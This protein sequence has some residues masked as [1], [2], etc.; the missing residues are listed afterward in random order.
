M[1]QQTGYEKIILDSHLTPVPA[2]V[3]LNILAFM[4]ISAIFCQGNGMLLATEI[5]TRLVK[6]DAR[7]DLRADVV[8]MFLE[9]S[10]VQEDGNRVGAVKGG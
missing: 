10:M 3:L 9:G 2:T 1:P 8:Q 7:S 6:L 5:C 4:T